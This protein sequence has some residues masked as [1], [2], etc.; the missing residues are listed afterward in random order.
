ML[1]KISKSFK[2]SL[3]NLKSDRYEGEDHL[4][5]MREYSGSVVSESTDYS[6]QS[7]NEKRKS[8]RFSQMFWSDIEEDTKRDFSSKPT[9]N[10]RSVS[11]VRFTL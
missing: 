2:G 1:A 8:K 6:M 4:G 10:M 3:G 7:R 5:N 11:M 9:F